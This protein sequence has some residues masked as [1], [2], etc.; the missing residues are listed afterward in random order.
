MTIRFI[1][2]MGKCEVQQKLITVNFRFWVWKNGCIK[3]WLSLAACNRK[4]EIV[5]YLEREIYC[6]ATWKRSTYKQYITGRTG[7]WS[8]E[9]QEPLILLWW[10]PSLMLPHG[11]RWLLDLQ[12]LCRW[13]KERI[14]HSE[15]SAYPRGMGYPWTAFPQIPLD[16]FAYFHPLW[17]MSK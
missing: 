17:T 7:P 1:Y 4:P 13:Q 11:L 2:H 9:T 15:N 12:P 10:L 3:S 5:V 8:S 14:Q 16:S 6:S